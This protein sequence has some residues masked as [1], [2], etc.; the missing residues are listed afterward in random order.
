MIKA[1]EAQNEDRRLSC[2]RKAVGGVFSR[3]G[4]IFHFR[5]SA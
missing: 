5:R 3:D 2:V 1:I 4:I